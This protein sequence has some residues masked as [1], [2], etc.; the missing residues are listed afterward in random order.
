MNCPVCLGKIF[1]NRN[2]LFDDRYGEPN[3]YWLVRCSQCGHVV[4]SPQLRQCDIPHLYGTYYPRKSVTA[5]QVVLEASSAAE[6]LAELRRWWSGTNNQ[7]QYSVLPGQ[8]MLDVGCGS[9]C[10][11]LE[12]QALGAQAFGIEAD[13]NVRP[14]AEKLGLNIH[15][16]KIE[17]V[18]FPGQH[19]DLIVLNQVIEHLLEPDAALRLLAQRLK[20]EGRLLLVM[21]NTG[22]LWRRLSGN[23][24]INWHVPYH[25]HHFNK[26]GFKRMAQACQLE[27]VRLRTITPNVWTLLQI[28]SMASSPQLGQASPIWAVAAPESRRS[29]A[30]HRSNP[31]KTLVRG[32]ILTAIAVVN[33]VVDALGLGDSL[34]VELKRQRAP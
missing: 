6:P 27:V 4:T 18:P 33:R 20:P 31:L 29:E 32:V 28:R 5:D 14:I 30:A 11:L 17:D 26:Q 25:Q 10:S 8:S 9:G 12:A 34:M 3:F 1:A 2:K 23:K 21:P 15:F 13:L 16:G 19:F 24:W 22:S 7:G